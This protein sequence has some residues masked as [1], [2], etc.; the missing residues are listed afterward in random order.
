M[1]RIADRFARAVVGL[2]AAA[3]VL[4][5]YLL[6]LAPGVVWSGA[7]IDSGDLAAA[8]AVGGVPH[9]T[10]Y[11][12][13]MLLG[14]AVRAIP[15]GDLALRLNVL[16]AL[17]AAGSLVPLGLLAARLRPSAGA[18]MPLLEAASGSA[19][20]ALYGLAPLVWSNAIV[21]EVYALASLCLWSALYT[22]VRARGSLNEGRDGRRW[23]AASGL[24]LGI[25]AGAHVTVA[26]AVPALAAVLLA[27]RRTER[28]A[29]RLGALAAGGFAAGCMVFAYLP[30]A[31]TLDPPINWGAPSTPERFWSVVSGEIYRS[32]LGAGDIGATTAKAAWLLG[33][34]VRQL[35]W[36][37]LPLLAVGGVSLTRRYGRTLLATGWIAISALAVGTI[38]TS[39]DDQVFTLPMLAVAALWSMLGVHE[40]ARLAAAAGA[41]VHRL[42]AAVLPTLLIATALIRGTELAPEISMRDATHAR[43]FAH[44]VLVQAES[45]S[46]L[47]TEDDRAT[48]PLWYAR[49]APGGRTDVTILDLRLWQFAW[50]RHLLGRHAGIPTAASPATLLASGKWPADRPLWAVDIEVGGARSGDV[51][52]T[53]RPLSP[54]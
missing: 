50:Y 37:L 26:L 13:L 41:G 31:A 42:V 18:A 8:V 36:V 5:A 15:L 24:L 45:G 54:P 1:P 46:V 51:M 48:F 21:T 39:R 4:V 9:P 38:Y 14:L 33:E 16:T 35:T 12:T 32:R 6:A 30:I 17:A 19:V 52:A 40:V 22:A 43:A 25:G 47:L 29:L 34:P 27:E 20:L 3:G 11:P 10:G 2:S 49:Y 44:A 7:G 53:L 28:A 23:A